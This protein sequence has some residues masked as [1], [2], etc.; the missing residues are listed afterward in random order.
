MLK[1][2]K[3]RGIILTVKMIQLEISPAKDIYIQLEVNIYIQIDRHI[4][5]DRDRHLDCI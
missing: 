2:L 1:T 4:T 3:A 5:L